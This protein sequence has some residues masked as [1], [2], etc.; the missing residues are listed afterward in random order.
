MSV[1]VTTT[2]EGN[3]ELIEK[4][5]KISKDLDI[6]FIERENYSLEKIMDK[7]NIENL[8][9]VEKDRLVLKGKENEFFWHPNMAELKI[10][11]IKSGN[12]E[13]IMEASKV[14]EGYWVLD[15]TLGL[16]GDAIIFSALVGDNGRVV[17]TEINKYIAYLTNDGLKNYNKVN[18]ETKRAMENIEVVNTSYRDYLMKQDDNSF[19]IVYFDPMFKKAN[20]KSTSINSFRDFADH[21][22]LT[23]DIIKEAIRVC[24]KRVVIK[25]R[26]GNNDFE[27][28]G[29]E[30]VYG[31]KKSGAIIYG[32]IEK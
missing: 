3:E 12:K 7:N 32:V 26:Q 10:Q 4:A 2:R 19:D 14:E 22:G 8:L 17:G 23:K 11:S 29:I 27:E 18:E 5:I 9:V 24:K 15:C 20:K 25:E 28:L 13:S 30:K 1:L 31:S 21:N 16:A 6:Q